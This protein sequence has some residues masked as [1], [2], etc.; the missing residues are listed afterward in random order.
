MAFSS[1]GPLYLVKMA[2]AMC[3]PDTLSLSGSSKRKRLVL[4][5]MFSTSDSF[6]DRKPWSPPVRAGLAGA[7]ALPPALPP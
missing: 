4:W 3:R 2:L 5:L 1:L 7:L 6:S